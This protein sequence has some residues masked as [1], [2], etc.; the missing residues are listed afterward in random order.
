MTHCGALHNF[1]F[2]DEPPS[3]KRLLLKEQFDALRALGIPLRS[4]DVT[5]VSITHPKM[6]PPCN[7]G[8]GDWR[9]Y[10][11]ITPFGSEDE[12]DEDEDLDEDEDEFNYNL[13]V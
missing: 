11:E 7:R 8:L 13:M 3:S 4:T 10:G 5:V 2:P 12:E 1:G 9:R 6:V